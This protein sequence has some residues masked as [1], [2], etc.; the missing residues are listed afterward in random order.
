M[1]YCVLCASCDGVCPEDAIL[2][3]EAW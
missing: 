3:H 2:N 1:D